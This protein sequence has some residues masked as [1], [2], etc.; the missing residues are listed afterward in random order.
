MGAR[1]TKLIR[2]MNYKKTPFKK[3][4]HFYILLILFGFQTISLKAQTYELGVIAGGANYIGDIGSTTYLGIKDYAYGGI[5]K[6]NASPRY[7][8]RASLMRLNISENDLDGDLR[9]QARGYSFSN[10]ITEFSVGIEFNFLEWDMYEYNTSF[11]PY[12]F[13]G[14]SMISYGDLDVSI[15]DDFESKQSNKSTFGF[16]IPMVVGMKVS[17]GHQFVL[18]TELGACYTF[19]DNL[20]GSY[21]KSFSESRFGNISN[22][23]WCLFAGLS[24]AYTWGNKPCMCSY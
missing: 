17:L 22:N 13:S 11:S 9:R 18:A 1:Q 14:I 4:Y 2:V 7:T 19:T 23:D 20:D 3:I 15:A 6:W 12:V 10:Q 21:S 24:L 8:Y 16:A 5:F